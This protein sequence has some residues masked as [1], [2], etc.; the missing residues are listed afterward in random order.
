M[1]P[2]HIQLV[3]SLTEDQKRVLRLLVVG[4]SERE[5]VQHESSE[6]H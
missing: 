2:Y 5:S 1:R 3:Q 4:Y 6:Y